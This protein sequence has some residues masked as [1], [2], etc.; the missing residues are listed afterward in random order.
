MCVCVCVCGAG[1]GGRDCGLWQLHHHGD[2]A[3]ISCREDFHCPSLLTFTV[4][5]SRGSA[6]DPTEPPFHSPCSLP[7][8]PKCI[9]TGTAVKDRWHKLIQTAAGLKRIVS[10]GREEMT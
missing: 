9:E 8:Y 5:L 10:F 3:T 6:P 1:S 7:D 2:S 4:V